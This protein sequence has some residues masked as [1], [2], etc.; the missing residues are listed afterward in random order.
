MEMVCSSEIGG[1]VSGLLQDIA[2]ETVDEVA[3]VESAIMNF[4]HSFIADSVNEDSR[5]ILQKA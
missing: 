5:R 2:Q 4:M 3:A 1:M